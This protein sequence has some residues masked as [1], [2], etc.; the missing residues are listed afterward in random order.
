MDLYSELVAAVQSDITTDASSSL[1]PPDTI[2]L[3]VNRAYMKIGGMHRWVETRDALKTSS[4]S[5]QEFYDYPDNWRTDS[6]IKLMVD[7]K[8]YGDPLAFVDYSYEKENAVPSGYQQMWANYNR[9][10]FIYPTPLTD[11]DNNISIWGYRSVDQLV[12]DGDPTIFSYTMPDVNEAIAIEAVAILKQKGEIMQVIRRT[13]MSGSELLSMD[14]RNLVEIAWGKVTQEQSRIAKTT[15]GWNVPDYFAAGI[16]NRN[17]L[18]NKI[19]Q[20]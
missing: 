14:A 13:Y 1:F 18:S 17:M 16:K 4:G 3:A 11:G 12:D 9:K 6:I 10:Y 5:N 2:K 7:G 8:D 15:P 20:F 19:G